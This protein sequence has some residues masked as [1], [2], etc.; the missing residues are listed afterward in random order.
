VG[1]GSDG[2]VLGDAEKGVAKKVQE[3]KGGESEGCGLAPVSE[4]EVKEEPSKGAQTFKRVLERH[5]A[6]EQG[7]LI[8]EIVAGRKVLGKA[9][10]SN[11][12]DGLSVEEQQKEKE[13]IRG[14][15]MCQK[16]GMRYLRKL[17]YWLEEKKKGV[18][19]PVKLLSLEEARV[20]RRVRLRAENRAQFEVAC[21]KNGCD[22]KVG[23]GK[24]KRP[25]Q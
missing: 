16:E 12:G 2:G 9:F 5:V 13:R 15:L 7:N 11:G 22:G 18:I 23:K 21:S 19:V 4:E 14:R 17:D 3:E 25:F 20:A 10:P 24:R 8:E 6:R 1:S